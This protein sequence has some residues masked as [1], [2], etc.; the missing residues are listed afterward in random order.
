MIQKYGST[1][2]DAGTTPRNAK[3]LLQ[4]VL[5]MIKNIEVSAQQPADVMLGNESFF[6]THKLRFVFIWYVSQRTGLLEHLREDLVM[7]QLP[8]V[9][10]RL[11]PLISIQRGLFLT[12]IVI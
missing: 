4:K 7:M 12:E 10:K 3:Y 11:E 6:T 2:P 1:V 5:N 8:V 9:M